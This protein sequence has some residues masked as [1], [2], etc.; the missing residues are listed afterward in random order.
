MLVRVDNNY[1]NYY[2]LSADRRNSIMGEGIRKHQEGRVVCGQAMQL[3]VPKVRLS[4]LNVGHYDEVIR[5][6]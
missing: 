5:K 2:K 3:N 6:L 1:K 4:F